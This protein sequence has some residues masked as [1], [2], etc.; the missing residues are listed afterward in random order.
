M[1]CP[2]STKRTRVKEQAQHYSNTPSL[3]YSI[4]YA[5]DMKQILMPAR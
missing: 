3:Q 4:K 5:H 2:I 1:G